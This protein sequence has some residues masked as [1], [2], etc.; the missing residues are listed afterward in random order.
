[1]AFFSGFFL[2]LRG[3]VR[4][5]VGIE[6]VHVIAARRCFRARIERRQ[7]RSCAACATALCLAIV[8]P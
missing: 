1:L 4:A 2:R 7:T 5:A 3:D 8:R 6:P